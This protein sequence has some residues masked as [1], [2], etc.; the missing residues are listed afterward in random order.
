MSLYQYHFPAEILCSLGLF[1]FL[2]KTVAKPVEETQDGITGI[3]EFRRLGNA[4]MQGAGASQG[5]S[6]P[7]SIATIR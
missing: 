2:T 5:Y 6:T 4:G 1:S 3:S 7:Q